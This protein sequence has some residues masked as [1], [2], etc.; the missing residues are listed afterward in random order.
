MKARGA[1]ATASRSTTG[2]GVGLARMHAQ[3]RRSRPGSACE[4]RRR[5][6]RSSRRRR[7]PTRPAGRSGP[8]RAR[9]TRS[10][11]AASL[12][13]GE[14]MRMRA[15]MPNQPIGSFRASTEADGAP[16]PLV[17]H[18]WHLRHRR[19]R[20]PSTPGRHPDPRRDD[21]RDRAPRARRGGARDP[22]RRRARHA[23]AEHHRRRRQPS[24]GQHRGR[25]GHRRVQ[26]RALQLPRAAR[27]AARQGPPARHPRR[28]GDDR[29]PLR[30]AR[31]RLR[32]PPA[33]DVRD[34]AVGQ[35]APPARA[36][37]R[38]HGRQAALLRARPRAGSPSPPRSRRCSPAAWYAPSWTRSAPSC[39]SPTGS[40][41]ART[42]CSPACA[43]STRRR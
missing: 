43:S 34:R 2:P 32:P 3:E 20:P 38:P 6:R 30:G 37:A 33:R 23:P 42:R 7:P 39:S 4:D 16:A 41:P 11:C 17:G 15:S 1:A 12:R 25:A 36:G 8:P 18:V 9:A 27:G 13:M 35:A 40:S 26:R 14:M 5:C 28:L 31:P 21:L 19:E 29:A 10:T 24:A 22:P